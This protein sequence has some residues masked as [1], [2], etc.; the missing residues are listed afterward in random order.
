[1]EAQYISACNEVDEVTNTKNEVEDECDRL[2][3]AAEHHQSVLEEERMS[4]QEVLEAEQERADRAVA[5]L[6]R[7]EEAHKVAMSTQEVL[8]GQLESKMKSELLSDHDRSSNLLSL[9]SEM[10]SVR[11]ENDRLKMTLN[12]MKELHQKSVAEKDGDVLELNTVINALKMECEELRALQVI[13]RFDTV[14]S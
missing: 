11:E 7:L 8:M 12:S 5:E 13:Y 1:M 3:E 9:R 4:T 10:D 6:K 14:H 2:H